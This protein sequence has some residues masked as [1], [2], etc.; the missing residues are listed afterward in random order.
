MRV[1][2]GYRRLHWPDLHGDVPDSAW[3][4]AYAETRCDERTRRV[5]IV[6]LVD[7]VEGKS[8][9]P[10]TIDD[11]IEEVRTKVSREHDV[12]FRGER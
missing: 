5:Q 10:T 12:P 4:K 8:G 9:L 11:G 7:N 6:N 1:N 2:M 3:H